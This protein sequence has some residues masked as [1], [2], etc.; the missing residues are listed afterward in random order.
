MASLGLTT[1]QLRS[2]YSSEGL[3]STSMYEDAM[4]F[5]FLASPRLSQRLRSA[6]AV[7]RVKIRIDHA[8]PSPRTLALSNACA[9]THKLLRM[10]KMTAA[11]MICVSDNY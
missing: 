3:L 9:Q 5:R 2:E 4:V 11:V 7:S 1:A 8:Q 10:P 6:L